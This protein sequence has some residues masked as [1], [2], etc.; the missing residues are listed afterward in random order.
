MIIKHLIDQPNAISVLAAWYLAEW[1]A[2]YGNNG[3]GDA[4]RDL[5]S[6]LS[7]EDLPVGLV[8]MEGEEVLATA[9]LGLD[10]TTNLTP[11]IIG[12]LVRPEKRGQGI[13]TAVIKGCEDVARGLGYR[14]LHVSTSVLGGLLQRMGWRK[15]GETKFLNDETG[16]VFVRDL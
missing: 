11:S 8:A 10:P 15:T 13:G 1:A 14:R 2:Y 9:A 7:R 6:R 3:P 5:E 12:L 16:S 4:R